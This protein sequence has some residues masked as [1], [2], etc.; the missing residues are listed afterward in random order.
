[1]ELKDYRL[2]QTM[3]VI[4]GNITKYGNPLGLKG[5]EVAG[6]SRGMNLPRQGEILFYTGGEYQLVPYIDS[7]VDM[8]TRMDQGSVGFSLLMGV[9]NLVDR[10]GI[11]AEKIAAGV[12]AKDRQRYQEVSRKACTV[13]QEMGLKVAYL[14]EEEIYSGALLYEFGF[15]NDLRQYAQKVAKLIETSGARTIVCLSPH[16]AEVFKF[17]YPRL[18]ENFNYEIKTFLEVVYDLSQDAPGRLPKG[19]NGSVTIHDSCRM[20]RELGIAEEIRQILGQMDGVTVLEA[21]RNRNWTSCCGGPSKV[22]MPEISSMVAGRRV[23]ELSDTGADLAL[24]F[25]PY[26]L[27]ALDMGAEQQ[28]KNLIIE[29]FIEFLYRGVAK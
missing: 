22:L 16:S 5:N 20:A 29:D 8:M 19:F 3:E 4:R 6:W 9:R 14:G 25:C 7:L 28:D 15:A 17:I 10:V 27:A 26:C 18:V 11:N 13:L 1:M 23:D 2:P 21:A 12:R 24:T